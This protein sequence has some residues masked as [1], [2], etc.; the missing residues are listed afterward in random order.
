M[1]K[2]IVIGSGGHAKS[3]VDIIESKN[4]YQIAGFMDNQESDYAYKDYRVIGSD[5]DAEKLYHEGIR[6]AVMG[7]GF[8]GNS[9][10]RNRVYEYY[11]SI[12]FQFPVCVDASA[13]LAND[14]ILD[15]GVVVG[16]RAVINSAAKIGRMAIVNTAATVE[17]ECTVGEFSHVS[18]G[19]IIC[20]NV[21]VGHD[22]F[23]GAGT[24]VIQGKHI[25]NR[26]LI[27][28]G[29]VV[30]KDVQS[31]EKVMGVVK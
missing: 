30:L 28:A 11:K 6:N 14:V 3:V 15:E 12:G 9:Q 18:V 1:E 19:A 7:I 24:T 22:T 16:K 25:G 17:H 23:V 8:L 21:T 2:I 13:V 26:A 27:G 29:S 10:V 20:G 4:Q 31:D 5:A